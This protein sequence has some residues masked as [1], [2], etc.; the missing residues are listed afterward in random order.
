MVAGARLRHRTGAVLPARVV[1]T[2]SVP[3]HYPRGATPKMR[4]AKLQGCGW[5]LAALLG[6]RAFTRAC[7]AWP[8]GSLGKTE[9]D[10]NCRWQDRVRQPAAIHIKLVAVPAELVKNVLRKLAEAWNLGC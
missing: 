3:R 2:W 5:P 1:N 6:G 8:R 4:S 7:A 9:A 10:R